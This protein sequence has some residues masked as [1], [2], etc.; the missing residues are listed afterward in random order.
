MEPLTWSGRRNWY[1][2]SLA[3]SSA[4]I[5]SA[6]WGCATVPKH[7]RACDTCHPL[8]LSLRSPAK[9]ERM[10]MIIFIVRVFSLLRLIEDNCYINNL[11][12]FWAWHYD[13]KLCWCLWANISLGDIFSLLDWLKRMHLQLGSHDT[14]MINP[15]WLIQ[16]I[17]SCT[18]YTVI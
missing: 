2:P 1:F 3:C 14:S 9:N 4:R 17:T 7:L 18:L 16:W 12:F 6:T 11:L 5:A 10:D 8:N 15:P 13:W